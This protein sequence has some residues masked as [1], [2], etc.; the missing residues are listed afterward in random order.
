MSCLSE[1]LGPV[2]DDR[3]LAV[4]LAGRLPVVRARQSE[5]PA[6]PPEL[7]PKHPLS[8]VRSRGGLSWEGI[9]SFG[10]S[11]APEVG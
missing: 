3:Y 6:R 11:S 7:S 8:H 5:D 9:P 2:A 4:T 1:A 10:M